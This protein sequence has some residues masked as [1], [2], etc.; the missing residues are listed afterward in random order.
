MKSHEIS[1]AIKF[2]T[3][4]DKIFHVLRINNRMIIA[5]CDGDKLNI[6]SWWEIATIVDEI[7][8]NQYLISRVI[9]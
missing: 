4:T 8:A 3:M 9:G 6:S 2:A 1:S 7:V 5:R